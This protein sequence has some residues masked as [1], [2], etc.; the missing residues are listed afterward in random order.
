MRVMK[1]EDIDV[2]L[3]PLAQR[4]GFDT[5]S[6]VVD[7][8]EAGRDCGRRIFCLLI[9][10][11]EPCVRTLALNKGVDRIAIGRDG[12]FDEATFVVF[13]GRGLQQGTRAAPHRLL[14]SVMDI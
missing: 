8:G 13:E 12:G 11:E 4:M 1:V 5:N 6:D 3:E 14:K 10:R 9:T 7:G 2:E